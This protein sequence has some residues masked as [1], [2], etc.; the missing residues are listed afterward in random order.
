M[1]CLECRVRVV[2]GGVRSGEGAGGWEQTDCGWD[3]MGHWDAM[4]DAAGMTCQCGRGG[5]QL[6]YFAGGFT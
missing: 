3:G 5:M 6:E 1:G 2:A 4:M